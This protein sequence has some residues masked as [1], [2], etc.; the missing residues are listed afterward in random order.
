MCGLRSWRLPVHRR[1]AGR[2]GA[3]LARPGSVDPGA[4]RVLSSG[5]GSPSSWSAAPLPPLR[6]RRDAI[7]PS[8][9][10]RLADHAAVSLRPGHGRE[11]RTLPI[12]AAG[13]GTASRRADDGQSAPQPRT[14][15]PED[16]LTPEPR[17]SLPGQKRASRA[18]HRAL[19]QEIPG[20]RPSE[21]RGLPRRAR[22]PAH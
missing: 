9:G 20:Y 15:E 10:E 18:K 12:Q 8:V 17:A 6:Q 19:S 14:V 21:P 5:S 11:L 2:R 16:G 3:S 7:W 1:V 22:W 4:A 13:G